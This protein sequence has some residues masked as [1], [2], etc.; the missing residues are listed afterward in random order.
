M[1]A[2]LLEIGF[3]THR[4]EERTLASAAHQEAIASAVARA[5]REVRDARHTDNDRAEDGQE[6]QGGKR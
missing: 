4:E 6:G 3:L 1:P 2:A 5:V